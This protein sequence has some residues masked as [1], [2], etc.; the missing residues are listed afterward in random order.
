MKA[1]H[2]A[3]TPLDAVRVMRPICALIK[4]YSSVIVTCGMLYTSCEV[5]TDARHMSSKSANPRSSAM[6]PTTCRI[7]SSTLRQGLASVRPAETLALYR[8]HVF[9]P[10]QSPFAT[11]TCCGARTPVSLA[12]PKS[13]G[14]A[15]PCE[16]HAVLDHERGLPTL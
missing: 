11:M 6:E 2:L 12:A 5:P 7:S 14:M 10:H 16:A 3:L 4:W 1:I 15:I 8:T 9:S 13:L